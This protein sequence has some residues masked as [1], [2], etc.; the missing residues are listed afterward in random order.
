[1]ILEKFNR[2]FG[3]AETKK[4][5]EERKK[6][7]L[8]KFRHA[9]REFGRIGTKSNYK[10]PLHETVPK[11]EQL[12]IDL[13]NKKVFSLRNR[14]IHWIESTFTYF[15]P[16]YNLFPEVGTKER[17][18][19]KTS[20]KVKYFTIGEQIEHGLYV[21]KE[22]KDLVLCNW[23]GELYDTRGEISKGRKGYVAYVITL[24]GRLITHGH[25]NPGKG[26]EWAYRH[27]TLAGGK[28]ILCSGLMKVVD[29]KIEY[30]DNNS[31]HYKPEAA[32]LYRAIKRLE[33]LFSKGSKDSKDAKIVCLTVIV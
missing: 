2:W 13:G 5:S 17:K 20:S 8:E 7:L 12:S 25:V 30:M 31:G 21:R 33:G 6:D 19:P 23:K 9:A 22:N 11:E 32:N 14:I 10:T 27:S 18:V 3:K 15:F 1:M 4:V 28:P 26:V 24:D 16:R 29:G